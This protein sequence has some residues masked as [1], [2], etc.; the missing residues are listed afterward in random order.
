[1]LANLPFHPPKV[2]LKVGLMLAQANFIRVSHRGQVGL[3]QGW[4]TLPVRDTRGAKVGLKVGL[5]NPTPI[6]CAP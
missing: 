6:G 1:M 3:R 4:P 2:G 5:E